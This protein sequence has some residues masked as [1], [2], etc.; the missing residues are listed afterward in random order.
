ML[1]LE[2]ADPAAPGLDSWW[3]VVAK[4]VAIFLFLTVMTLFV[5]VFERKIVA[6]MQVRHGPNQVGPGGWLQALT[7]GV[8]LILKEDIRA[9][10]SDRAVLA[11]A[12]VI[13]VV[14]AFTAFSIIPFGPVVSVFGERTALQLADPP[15]GVMVALAC[16][17]TGIYGVVLAGWASG[18]AYPLLGGLR[19]AAQMIS[20]EVVIG[21]SMVGVLL[22]T[23]SMRTSD[24]VAEQAH[25]TTLSLFGT[26]LHGLPS[27]NA[28]VLLPSFLSYLAG[29]V[30]ETNRAPFDLAE[31]ESE[32]VGGF[33]TEYSSVRFMLM[34]F[35]EYINVITVCALCTTLYLGGWR[36][37]WPLSA[38]AG[39]MLNQNW[40]PVL[41]FIAKVLLLVFVF[42]WLR[43]TLPRL[44]YDQYMRFSWKVLLPAGL[45]WLVLLA[46]FRVS[47]SDQALRTAVL[48]GF[49]VL[50]LLIVLARPRRRT[51]PGPIASPPSDRFPIPPLDLVVPMRPPAR[52]PAAGD[53]SRPAGERNGDPV[54]E[55]T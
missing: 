42:V 36:A 41:W 39:G 30:G 8:K 50:L 33:H 2:S 7:D 3:I 48:A 37:P 10:A 54:E 16:T 24:I 43:G 52:R 13:A 40:W 14:C 27:W 1:L 47:A 11:A 26:T 35:A 51:A 44:R 20:Y 55:P 29:G 6:R 25:G 22:L 38:I 21:L 34:Y 23:G 12:P 17:S 45:V 32:L 53:P 4:T 46:G 15:I 31:A 19:S 9:A 18:S 49:A 28:I 5:I